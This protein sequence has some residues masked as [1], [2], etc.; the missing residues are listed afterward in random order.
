MKRS[1]TIMFKVEEFSLGKRRMG[2]E[3]VGPIESLGKWRVS[4]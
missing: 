4:G 2:G 3:K 1:A